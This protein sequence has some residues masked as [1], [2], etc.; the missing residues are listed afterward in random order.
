MLRSIFA[1]VSPALIVKE[2]TARTVLSVAESRLMDL[3]GRSSDECLREIGVSAQGL[4]AEEVDLRRKEAGL[5]E[6]SSS[7][8]WE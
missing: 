1:K 4:T 5:T 6:A 7:L 8:C 2:A 3:C